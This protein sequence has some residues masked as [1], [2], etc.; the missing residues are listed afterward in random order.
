[1]E[2]SKQ[3]E[4][5]ANLMFKHLTKLNSLF[6]LAFIVASVLL[7]SRCLEYEPRIW[8]DEG[9]YLQM[10]KNLVTQG[11]YGLQTAPGV[12]APNNVITIGPPVIFI[13]TLFMKILG[14]TL[15]AA[16]VGMVFFGILFLIAAYALVSRSYGEKP[17]LLSLLLLVLFNPLYNNGKIVSGE[18][19]AMFFMAL[20]LYFMFKLEDEK[21]RNLNYFL[22]SLFLGLATTSK[23]IFALVIAA[24]FL[25]ACAQRKKIYF[26]YKKL[27]YIIVGLAIPL[28]L[29]LIIQV[30]HTPQDIAQ[31]FIH[32]INVYGDKEKTSLIIAHNIL[33]FFKID[34]P[35]YF[36]ILL[37]IGTVGT[38][39]RAKSGQ[40]KLIELTIITYGW[41]AL[42]NFLRLD[43]WYRYFFPAQ[44]LLIL[45]LPVYLKE[46]RDWIRVKSGAVRI[47]TDI[48]LLIFLVVVVALHSFELYKK[49]HGACA[50]EATAIVKEAVENLA[51]TS[52]KIY[53]LDTTDPAFFMPH[54]QY[55]QYVNLTKVFGIGGDSLRAIKDSQ[56]DYVFIRKEFLEKDKKYLDAYDLD[57]DIGNFLIF[58]NKNL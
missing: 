20:G 58:K 37:M 17:A 41:L 30:G 39:L 42:F 4:Y 14:S 54:N 24:A 57:Q 43:P 7:F 23:T 44:V 28:I 40:P 36:L 16:R 51:K 35:L 11:A 21:N 10:V 55:Y 29:W 2:Q 15:L 1:M 25:V 33:L 26:S 46:L 22:V 13:L 52:N 53:F 6:L 56:A 45:L 12:F 38:I 9:V 50:P 27:L 18:V 47:I 3:L 5:P 31:S 48:S 32:N 49:Q 34:N 19:P 8:M